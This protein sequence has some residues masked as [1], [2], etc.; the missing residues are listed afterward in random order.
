MINLMIFK[1]MAKNLSHYIEALNNNYHLKNL[2][3]FSGEI[4]KYSK[5]FRASRLTEAK[6]LKKECKN[7]I[8][9][10]KT[11]M[12]IENLDEHIRA[13]ADFFV[14]CHFRLDKFMERT[15]VMIKEQREIDHK[16]IEVPEAK[17]EKI[18]LELPG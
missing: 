7:L 14:Q 6:N 17:S 11:E 5:D 2:C 13:Y 15:N 3:K 4:G 10:A 16:A 18:S 12:F 1:M 9:L 8:Y